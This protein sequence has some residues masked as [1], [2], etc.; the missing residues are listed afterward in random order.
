M[1]DRVRLVPRIGRPP[2]IEVSKDDMHDM[3]PAGLVDAILELGISAKELGK[4][5]ESGRKVRIPVNRSE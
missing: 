2:V 4:P 5:V 1:D 3:G